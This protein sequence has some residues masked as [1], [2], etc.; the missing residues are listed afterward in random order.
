MVSM[1]IC[2]ALLTTTP[3]VQC[4]SHQIQKTQSADWRSHYKMFL[5][6]NVNN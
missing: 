2:I 1:F 4:A 5:N 6:T 3:V